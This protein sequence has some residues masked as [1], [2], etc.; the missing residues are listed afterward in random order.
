[1][2]MI[3][4]DDSLEH[5]L[6]AITSKI[7]DDALANGAVLRDATG[8]LSFVSAS[9]S[10][11]ENRRAELE[12]AFSI[13]LGRYARPD[14]VLQFAD[15]PG[16]ES[17]LSDKDTLRV[18]VGDYEC[19]LIDRRIVGSGW[20][21]SPVS[22]VSMPPRVVFASLKGGVGRSTALAVTAFDL[23]A[24]GRNVLV[25]DLDLEA[26]GLGDLLLTEE[27]TPQYGVIDYLV[28]NGIGTISNTLLADFVGVSPLT[29]GSGG[30]VDVVPALGQRSLKYP[31]NVLPKLAR[32]MIE[33]ISEQGETI[34]LST[35]ISAMI[36]R[37][38]AREVYDV[39][40]IDSRAGLAELAAPAVLGLGAMVFLFGTAQKQTITG[41]RALFA[42]LN[43]LA[44]RAVEHD[45]S[46]E[47]RYLFKPVY[48]KSGL[49]PQ[50]N[51]RHMDDLY[52]LFLENLY[53]EDD[54]DGSSMSYR[55]DDLDAP[56]VPL[57][58]PFDPRFVDFDPARN[59]DHL[60]RP[61]YEQTYRPFLDAFDRT[62]N[63]M[64]P[65]N[66]K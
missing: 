27:R 54:G 46:L 24:R 7:G 63:D 56:H 62:L 14:R 36:D 49:D 1:M 39:I 48:A 40:L 45:D 17:L 66:E 16:A 38:S 8:L 58:I 42:G 5:L 20:L 22:S 41:Y 9:N 31:Q 25:F 29:T 52:D 59:R 60:A 53:D 2:S 34:S 18:K 23:A 11:E 21:A 55:V 33:D 50:V 4:F 6:R 47:W 37:L 35:Q 28:E 10:P 12:A 61:F 19:K 44:T 43:L 65:G 32:A 57:V 3:F 51:A 26:P 13:A 30:R 15:D 64:A